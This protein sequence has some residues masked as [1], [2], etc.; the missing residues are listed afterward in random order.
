MQ[1][2]GGAVYTFLQK[3]CYLFAYIKKKQYLCAQFIKMPL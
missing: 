1:I 2:L 3:K